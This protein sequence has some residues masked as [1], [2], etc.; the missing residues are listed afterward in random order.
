MAPATGG[1]WLVQGTGIRPD[2]NLPRARREVGAA[3]YRNFSQR[4]AGN[5]LA[6][7]TALV[8]NAGK[9]PAEAAVMVT[10]WETSYDKISAD[11]DQF[12]A[13]AEQNA[14]EA[15]ARVSSALAIMASWTFLMFGV[16]AF[17][18]AWGGRCGG[19]RALVH[20]LQAPTE[21]FSPAVSITVVQ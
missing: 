12:D 4:S 11:L 15:A 21:T 18:A 7:V 9:T 1:V 5:H 16:G 13:Q 17:A 6:L 14:K 8:D 19:Q 3:L 10:Q 20:H 2:V